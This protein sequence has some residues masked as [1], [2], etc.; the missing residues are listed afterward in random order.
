MNYREIDESAHESNQDQEDE[1]NE[2]F[3]DGV[4]LT[5]EDVEVAGDEAEED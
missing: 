2:L 3:D 5:E 4:P 1:D